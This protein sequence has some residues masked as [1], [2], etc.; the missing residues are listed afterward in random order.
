ML[1]CSYQVSRGYS[2]ASVKSFKTKEKKKPNLNLNVSLNEQLNINSQNQKK[3]KKRVT[4]M[5]FFP[6]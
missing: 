2:H 3:D 1:L 4:R 5:I 6:Y